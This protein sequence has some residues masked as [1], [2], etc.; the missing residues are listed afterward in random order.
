M[1][2]YNTRDKKTTYWTHIFSTIV[3]HCTGL[4]HNYTT[5]LGESEYTKY[6]KKNKILEAKIRQLRNL[7]NKTRHIPFKSEPQN[8]MR[9]KINENNEYISFQEVWGQ[10]QKSEQVTRKA[11]D[12]PELNYKI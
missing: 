3:A 8:N 2:K 12:P 11:I 6:N 5:Q 10:P 1:S 7:C 4:V 9:R